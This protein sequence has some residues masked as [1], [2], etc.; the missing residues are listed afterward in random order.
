MIYIVKNGID[1][2][3]VIQGPECDFGPLL[4][5]WI[6]KQIGPIPEWKTSKPE[7][8]NGP[9]PNFNNAQTESY[10]FRRQQW[11]DKYHALDYTEFFAAY[12]ALPFKEIEI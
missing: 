6:L 9:W 2:L 7:G 5:N 8:W 1:T 10:Y 4:T 3:W 11:W 12:Q